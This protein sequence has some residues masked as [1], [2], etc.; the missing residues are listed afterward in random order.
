[1]AGFKNIDV[2]HLVLTGLGKAVDSQQP[3]AAANVERLRRVHPDKTP[4][5]LVSYLNKTYLAAVAAAGAGAGM[6]AAVPNGVVQ[7]PVAVADLLTFLEASTLYALS[8]AEVHEIHIEDVE[9]RRLLVMAVLIGDGASVRIMDGLLGRAVPHWGRLIVDKIPM[10]AINR[11][12]KI[13]G[14]RFVTKYGAK[15][16]VLVLGMQVPALIGAAI[17]GG[18][19]Y[20]F[21]WMTIN[22]AKRILGP[23]PTT[24]P[25]RDVDGSV[26]GKFEADSS[27]APTV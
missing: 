14:P 9:R 6:A 26:T 12:N 5:Q 3:L 16:G 21:G 18:G 15:Q 20:A 1:M 2:K 8:V 10:V 4:E 27:I 11:A 24:W 13:L 23:P 22:A 25:G 7:V 19:N 17:G